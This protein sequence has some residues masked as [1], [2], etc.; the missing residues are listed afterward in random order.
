MGIEGSVVG[1]G[2][3]GAQVS[4][5]LLQLI[6]ADPKEF[7]RRMALIEQSKKDFDEQLKK[8]QIVGDILALR[9]ESAD[10][11]NSANDQL[12]KVKEDA[13]KLTSAAT[14]KADKTV[15]AAEEKA[16]DIIAKAEAAAAEEIE[17]AKKVMDAAKSAAMDIASRE[18]EAQQMKLDADKKYK[19]IEP[20]R[21]E[22]NK[23]SALAV[24]AT[25]EAMK[26]K[27]SYEA[28]RVALEQAAKQIAKVLGGN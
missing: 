3:G 13:K 16:A 15:S 4:M 22:F 19:S 10:A 7:Q 12:S 17:A 28:Q 9:K 23:Q 26:A 18:K 21:L 11:I 20:D 24:E 25:G 14:T 6:A 5:E 2:A 27:E 8:N 1:D